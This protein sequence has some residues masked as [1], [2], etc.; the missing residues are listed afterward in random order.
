L[1]CGNGSLIAAL[2]STPFKAAYGIDRS[3]EFLLQARD[4]ISDRRVEF[5]Q[6]DVAAGLPYKDGVFDIVFTVFVFNE[7]RSLEPTVRAV[8]RV[9]KENGMFLMAMTHLFY[10]LNYYLYEKFTGRE[11]DKIRN[12]RGYFEKY[13]AEYIFALAKV[14]APFYHHTFQDVVNALVDHSLQIQT[15]H[16][17]TVTDE[18]MRRYPA[19]V[20]GDDIPRYL[21]I[22]ARKQ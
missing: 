10:P 9:L 15:L 3:T 18:I 2:L 6:G 20:G 14:G 12:V 8:A 4:H 1:G 16:E 11:N 7:L 21:V 5:Q 19:Y 17:L 22:K 13:E